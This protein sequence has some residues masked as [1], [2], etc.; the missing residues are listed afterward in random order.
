MGIRKRSQDRSSQALF[1]MRVEDADGVAG[2]LGQFHGA[3]LDLVHRAAWAVRGE[4]RRVP[5][6]DCLGERQ[7]AAASGSRAGSTRGQKAE[8]LN[9]ARNQF[10][11]ETAAD[12]DRRLK[13][14]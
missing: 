2:E 10:A 1:R 13:S 5:T 11:V 4:D 12:Q 3:G 8:L 6:L 7:Q 9:R 14:A